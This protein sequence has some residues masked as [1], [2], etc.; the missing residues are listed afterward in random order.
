MLISK[1]VLDREH[2][3]VTS[4]LKVGT[5][6]ENLWKAAPIRDRRNPKLRE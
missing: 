4:E 2:C 5:N 3:I 6:L 1:E